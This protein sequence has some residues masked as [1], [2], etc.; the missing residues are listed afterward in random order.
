MV[1]ENGKTKKYKPFTFKAVNIYPR[2]Q[3]NEKRNDCNVVV[4]IR[5]VR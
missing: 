4:Y 3:T 5:V 1:L 2:R